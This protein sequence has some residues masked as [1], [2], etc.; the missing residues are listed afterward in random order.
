MKLASMKSGRDGKLFVV[1]RDLSR[2]ADASHIAPTLQAALDEWEPLEPELRR[3]SI[4]VNENAVS[5]VPFEVELAC[6]PLPRA[7]QSLS[8]MAYALR[9]D[10]PAKPQA[11]GGLA[12]AASG[13]APIITQRGSDYLLSPN[14]PIEVFD[15][16]GWG[17]DFEAE[18]A[19]VV[20]DTP[21]GVVPAVARKHIKLIMLANSVSLRGLAGEELALGFGL[22]R[23]KPAT[24]FAP[25]AVTPDE[26]GVSWD[27]GSVHLPLISRVNGLEFG[28]PNAGIDMTYNFPSLITHIAE[29]RNL[30]AGAI[31]GSGAVSNTHEGGPAQ[32]ISD[33]GLGCSCIAEM[34][35]I[36]GRKVGAPITPYLNHNDRLEIEMLDAQGRSVFGKID[37]IVQRVDRP[38]ES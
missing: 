13:G 21:M 28:K 22:L 16:N 12:A 23:S 17:V 37:Q 14:D 24:A 9:A 5:T 2:A 3:L 29:T 4:Q 7:Y 26:I 1:S 38:F 35:T 34:R 11:N 18:I 8:S 19:V 15:T 10:M 6:A 27:G 25:V 33:G 32:A 30:C 31:I 20:D 36:E